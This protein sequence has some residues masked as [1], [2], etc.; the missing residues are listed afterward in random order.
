MSR[1]G[2]IGFAVLAGGLIYI[3][4]NADLK[5]KEQLDY[6]EEEIKGLTEVK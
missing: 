6:F 3:V 2:I 5:S 1:V 4:Y